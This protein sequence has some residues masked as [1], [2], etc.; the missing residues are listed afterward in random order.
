MGEKVDRAGFLRRLLFVDSGTE[1]ARAFRGQ[2]HALSG[3]IPFTFLR[4]PGAPLEPQ[5][6]SQCTRCDLCREACPEKI[7]VPAQEPLM[8]TGSPV[9]APDLGPCTLCLKCIEACPDEALLLDEDRRMG[10]AVWHAETC[11]SSR[12]VA[13]V[14][15][16]EA[17]PV[18]PSAIQI[19]PGKGVDIFPDG[20]TGC[21]F[22]VRACPTDPR[23]LHLQGRPPMPL[24]GHP[25]VP[26]RRRG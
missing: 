4:P 14:K 11:L 22:C 17:C 25:P 18:G 1:A 3:R 13:C 20:C 8:G 12:I 23:S 10:R 5:F 19:V 26:R 9:I 24:R 15:C 21:G 16:A 2:G 6:L 7:I